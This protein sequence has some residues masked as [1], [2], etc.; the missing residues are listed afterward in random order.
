MRHLT[1][2]LAAVVLLSAS[3][4]AQEVPAPPPA[5]PRAPAAPVAPAPAPASRPRA[6]PVPP[7]PP[8]V[9]FDLQNDL[10]WREHELAFEFDRLAAEQARQAVEQSLQARI[11]L[12][13]QNVAP[14]PF[15]LEGPVI[16]ASSDPVSLYNAG[17]NALQRRSYDRAIQLFD[18]VVA[19]KG[20]HV[21]AATYWKAF[22]QAR[23]A[24]TDDALAT[25]AAF[26]RDSPRS[27][28]ANDAQ[29]LETEVRRQAGQRIDPQTLDA[30]DEIKLIAINGIAQTD[31][32]R[33]IP[34]LEGVLGAANTLGLKRRTLFVLALN[35]DPRARAILVRYAK[36]GG[37]PEL[38][39]E[40]VRHLVSRGSNQTDGVELREIY[41]STQDIS[42]RRA[43]VSALGAA[44]DAATLVAL[45]RT[46][47]NLD[48]R[49]SLVS[50]LSKLAGKN[51]VAA[52]Y[53]GEMIK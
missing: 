6:V 29:V 21:D 53:L 46:E 34:L 51:Q 49:R 38:Q 19:R 4:A 33:A 42:V 24:R 30:N 43:V 3:V 26:R 52:D 40:A 28:Y 37:T 25:L 48:L 14:V 13:P 45:A 11:L 16:A 22:S 1:S 50:A 44:N 7:K 36:G 18:L 10:A 17:L 9:S 27:R 47:T 12:N 8:F 35:E 31:P 2:C 41:M 15:E 32:D 20:S 5:P 39:A 23:L